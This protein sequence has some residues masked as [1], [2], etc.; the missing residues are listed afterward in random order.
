MTAMA[1]RSRRGTRLHEALRADRDGRD[2]NDRSLSSL[3]TLSETRK[4]SHPTRRSTLRIVHDWESRCN[5]PFLIQG[6]LLP[7]RTTRFAVANILLL[8]VGVALRRST[9]VVHAFVNPTDL[10]LSPLRSAGESSTT[11]FVVYDPRSAR[12][13][14][15]G[16]S[17]YVRTLLSSSATDDPIRRKRS[18]RQRQGSNSTVV[19]VDLSDDVVSLS[20]SSSSSIASGTGGGSEIV[21]RTKSNGRKRSKASTSA[22]SRSRSTKWDRMVGMLREFRNKHGHSFVATEFIPRG[23]NDM[24][25]LLMWTK[26]VRHN[27]RHQVVEMQHMAKDRGEQSTGIATQ[28]AWED[29]AYL[30]SGAAAAADVLVAAVDDHRG[31]D[32]RPRLSSERLRQLWELDFVWD[33]QQHAW[34]TKYRQL[35]EFKERHGHCR[36]PNNSLEYPRLGVWVRNQRRER[37][38]L[39]MLEQ[40]HQHDHVASHEWSSANADPGIVKSSTLT[41][42]RLRRL[43]ALGFDWYK[44]HDDTW[45]DKFRQLQQYA[46]AFG[47]ANVKQDDPR[48]FALGQWCMNQRIA[49]RKRQRRRREVREEAGDGTTPEDTLLDDADKDSDDGLTL[50]R[51]QRLERVG[52]SWHVRDDAWHAMKQ[53]LVDFYEEHGHVDIPTTPFESKTAASLGESESRTTEVRN[54]ELLLR[55]WLNR[56]RHEY[57]RLKEGLP[58]PM[59]MERIRALEASVPNFSW[60]VRGLH[61]GPSTED[62]AK[63]FDAMRAKGLTPGMRPKSHWF[64]GAHPFKLSGSAA[65][66]ATKDVWTEQDLLA[67]WNQESEEEEEDS[68]ADLGLD[69]DAPPVT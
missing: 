20:A 29:G 2:G 6:G 3:R 35:L 38:K 59:T 56:Q 15:R 47:H 46:E 43:E 21:I 17:P 36:V 42:E 24:K 52:F 68:D 22:S 8:F 12:I 63:L 9:V 14:P 53:K 30:M 26:S 11:A 64:E 16:C 7:R 25:E 13:R 32:G 54:L 18:A 34:E 40:Q 28:F 37:K 27:Y 50:T 44:S 58:S 66:A 62:W 48:Y 67:L 49:Y 39:M 45:N 33:A 10:L 57:K 23:N 69:G 19:A 1:H 51:I 41:P 31:P 55:T 5:R 61:S 60:Q 65:L 4:V